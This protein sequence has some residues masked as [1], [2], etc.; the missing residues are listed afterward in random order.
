M[1]HQ[2]LL[3]AN[4]ARRHFRSVPE[5]ESGSRAFPLSFL[6]S[7]SSVGWRILFLDCL[8]FLHSTATRTPSC[9]S[10]S[11]DPLHFFPYSDIREAMSLLSSDWSKR[12]RD[13]LESKL[14]LTICVRFSLAIYL[15]FN[16]NSNNSVKAQWLLSLFILKLQFENVYQTKKNDYHAG[17]SETNIRQ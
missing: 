11:R 16:S 9:F 12:A 17:N 7:S 8:D 15:I 10:T 1:S 13:L 5:V 4:R 6:S 14:H 2:T 3:C